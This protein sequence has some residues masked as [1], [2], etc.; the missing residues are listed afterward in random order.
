VIRGAAIAACLLVF[1]VGSAAGAT[2]AGVLHG[3]VLA[4][5]SEPICMPRLPCLHPASGVVL[6]F[7]RGG[8]VR[9][10]VTTRA[11][12]TYRVALLP[13]TYRVLGFSPSPV[14]VVAGKVMRVT[15]HANPS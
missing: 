6:A 11:G 10:R 4:A 15:F 13:G 14:R 2:R 9:A 12:G 3:T 7:S 1:A 5:G 8:V